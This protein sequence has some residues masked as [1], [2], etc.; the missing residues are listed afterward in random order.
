VSFSNWTDVEAIK[1]LRS[2]YFRA[3]DMGD[4]VT[5]RSLLTEDVVSDLKGSTYHFQ[6]DNREELIEAV[7]NALNAETACR[8]LGHHPE[9]SLT[10]PTT[11]EGIWYLQD[12]ALH[13]PTRQVLEGTAIIRDRY[14]KVDGA[15]KICYYQ[16]RR[17]VE[18]TYPWPEGARLTS[19]WLGEHGRK[20]ADRA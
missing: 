2:R 13:L 15:W 4:Y 8:H 18:F 7:A 12:W 10:G 9:I 11:A 16:Y 17:V 3:M 5:Y 6:F 19:H 20:H 1:I 14:L